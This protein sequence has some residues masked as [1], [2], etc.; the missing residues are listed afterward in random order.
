M[1]PPSPSIN[2]LFVHWLV[3]QLVAWSVGLSNGPSGAPIC[4]L[5][6]LFSENPFTFTVASAPRRR[7][8]QQNTDA[9]D[10]DGEDADA[11]EE[12]SGGR[13]RRVISSESENDGDGVEI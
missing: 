11:E 8:T 3:G 13:R 7:A 4:S 1:L 2:L 12:E 6:F 10:T 5:T 9:V